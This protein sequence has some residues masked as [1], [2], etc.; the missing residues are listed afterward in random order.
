MRADFSD[1][2][3]IGG[4]S[5][6]FKR[7]EMGNSPAS[8]F[9]TPRHLAHGRRRTE[10]RFFVRLRAAPAKPILEPLT[11]K[12]KIMKTDWQIIREL[13]NSVID[14]CE[15]IENLELTND[16]KD[17]PLQSAPANVW[18]ALQSTWTYPENVQCEVIRARHELDIDKHYTPEAARALVNAAKACAELI[19]AGDAESV[20][21]P[22]RKL[23]QW[24]SGHLVPQ[25]TQAVETNRKLS[26]G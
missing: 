12:G 22:V 23:T 19:E 20:A 4:A 3:G 24:Y 8:Y 5:P 13:M 17:L 14:S 7:F 2:A 9:I 26:A 18:D 16:D 25:V 21:D 15:A 1:E 10:W 6:T 11:G